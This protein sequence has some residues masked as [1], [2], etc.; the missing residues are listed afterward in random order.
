M[1]LD[2]DVAHAVEDLRREQGLGMSAAVNYL[3][4][5]GLAVRVGPRDPFRQ[6]VSSLGR[7]RVPL[8][9]IAGVLDVIEG[10]TRPG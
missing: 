4:R 8:D 7:S 3:A 5:Q 6:R 9:D 1:T 10:E 2:D